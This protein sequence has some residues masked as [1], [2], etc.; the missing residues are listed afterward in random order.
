M[1]NAQ[2]TS[3]A[4]LPPEEQLIECPYNKAHKVVAKR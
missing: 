3:I 1:I 4:D 2:Y